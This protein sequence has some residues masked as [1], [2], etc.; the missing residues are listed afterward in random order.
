MDARVSFR[1]SV[2]S[3]HAQ[4][5]LLLHVPNQFLHASI[6]EVEVLCRFGLGHL[7]QGALMSVF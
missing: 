1:L 5:E 6:S 7:G 2:W 4:S 3:I